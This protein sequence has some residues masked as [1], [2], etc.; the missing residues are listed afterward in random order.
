MPASAVLV[1]E[2]E[3]TL[4]LL[5]PLRAAWAPKGQQ[6]QVLISGRNAKRVIFGAVNPR[7]DHR[8]IFCSQ[9]PTQEDFRAFL[10]EVRRRYGKRPVWLLLDKGPSHTACKSQ[11]LAA[12]LDIT[13]IWLPTQCSELNPVDHLWRFLKNK[14]AANRQFATIDDLAFYAIQ[15]ITQLSARQTLRLAGLLSPKSWLKFLGT[16]FWT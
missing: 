9:R 12:D 5:P 16:N 11:Q 3:T 4:H 1:I 7:T 8:I 14:A 15:W 2:D 6:T 13:L 10:W